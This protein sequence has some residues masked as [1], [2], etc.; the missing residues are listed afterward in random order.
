V[1]HL[2]LIISTVLQPRTVASEGNH[3][4]GDP[5]DGRRVWMPWMNFPHFDGGDVRIHTIMGVPDRR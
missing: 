4:E 2:S 1:A 3:E 5:D